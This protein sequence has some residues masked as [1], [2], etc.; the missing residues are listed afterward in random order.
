MQRIGAAGIPAGAV[1]DTM[2]L[3]NDESFER[4]GIMQ[5]MR[6]P[7]HGDFKMPAWPVRVDGK[8]SRIQPS[9]V[10]GQHTDEV[11]GS[12]L[13]LSEAELAGLRRDGAL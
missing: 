7:Q 3:Q 10:L 4:R 13:G 11:L 9:P 5:V 6:H 1:L 12:W 2:E 8:P